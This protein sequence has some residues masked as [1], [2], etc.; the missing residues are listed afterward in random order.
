MWFN[1][2]KDAPHHLKNVS[3]AKGVPEFE[4]PENVITLI[5]LDDLMDS[6]HSTNGSGSFTKRSHNR[7]NSLLLIT[8]NLF[9]QVPAARDISLKSKYII[10]FKNPRI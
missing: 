9:H 2:E 10:V 7:N 3:F 8:Q 6:A 4:N 1:C 5:V